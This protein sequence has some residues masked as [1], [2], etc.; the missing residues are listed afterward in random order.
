[1]NRLNPGQTPAIWQCAPKCQT[2]P[3]TADEAI[4]FLISGRIKTNPPDYEANTIFR[5]RT[6][7]GT[8]ARNP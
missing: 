3:K 5:T 6:R 7:Y 4:E 1:M 8:S 2:T